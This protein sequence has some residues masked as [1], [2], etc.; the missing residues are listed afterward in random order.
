MRAVPVAAQPRVRISRPDTANTLGVRVAGR[1]RLLT[2]LGTGSS[3]VV[4]LAHDDLLDRRVAVKRIDQ[5]NPAG[6]AIAE[7][8]AAA[9]VSHANTVQVHDVISDSADGAEWVIMEALSGS[10]FAD[11]LRGATRI[12]VHETRHVARCVLAALAAM[13]GAGLVHRDVK[14]ANIQWC[15]DGRVVLLDFGLADRPGRTDP[16]LVV[17]SLPFLAPEILRGGQY[18]AASDLYALGM[19]LHC[20]LSGNLPAIPSW[21]LDTGTWTIPPIGVLPASAAP[22]EP[23]V[24]GLLHRSPRERLTAERTGRLLGYAR[25]RRASPD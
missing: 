19:T 1:Y 16:A 6:R 17:G 23:V 24:R 21:D 13:H 20:A 11:V 22:L 18:S 14:P 25:H 8:R 2:V 9:A 3:G 10:S 5:D 15:A 4:W 7:A 12:G